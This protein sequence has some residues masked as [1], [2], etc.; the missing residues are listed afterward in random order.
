MDEKN[1]VL[2]KM[3]GMIPIKDFNVLFIDN[4][5]KIFWLE[6]YSLNS[7]DIPKIFC[8]HLKTC[9]NSFN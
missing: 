7:V 4:N 6:F 1:D 5:K 2:E 8:T 3:K 9:V